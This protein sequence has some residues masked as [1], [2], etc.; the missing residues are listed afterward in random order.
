MFKNLCIFF[1]NL[2]GRKSLW[3][4]EAYLSKGAWMQDLGA[5]F[6]GGQV[7]ICRTK[8]TD[9]RGEGRKTTRGRAFQ[10]Y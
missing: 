6:T 4:A 5:P 9:S 2:Y 10:G 7:P 3:S 1:K 8:G